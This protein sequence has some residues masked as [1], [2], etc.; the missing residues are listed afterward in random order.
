M[1]KRKTIKPMLV[2]MPELMDKH[3]GLYKAFKHILNTE[4]S[5]S[6]KRDG[7]LLDQLWEKRGRT[8]IK[9]CRQ[10]SLKELSEMF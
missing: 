7:E 10:F 8:P 3:C 6:F 5:S 2:P 9:C 1:R 4:P